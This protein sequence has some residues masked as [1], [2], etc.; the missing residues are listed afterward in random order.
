MPLILKCRMHQ[1]KY[2]ESFHFLYLMLLRLYVLCCNLKFEL[3]VSR[4]QLLACSGPLPVS[5]VPSTLWG[6]LTQ[7]NIESFQ[8][9]S[10]VFFDH[11]YTIFQLVLFLI[12]YDCFSYRWVVSKGM[13]ILRIL[14]VF[15][16][17]ELV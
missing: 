7:H 8:T 10:G 14:S 12:A 15:L 5:S 17:L 9:F 3:F 6:I 1:N 13:V 4:F 16:L 11:C 2:G